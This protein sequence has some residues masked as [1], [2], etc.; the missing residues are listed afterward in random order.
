MDRTVVFVA[1]TPLTRRQRRD[2]EK[3]AVPYG[4]FSSRKAVSLLNM[5]LMAVHGN[6]EWVSGYHNGQ[7]YLN[8]KLIKER[9]KDL[10]EMRREA[11]SFLTRMAGVSQAWTVDD[12]IDRR[13]TDNPDATRRNTA[14]A[15]A[16]D[17]F[18]AIAPGWQEIDDDS[19]VEAPQTRPSTPACWPRQWPAFCAYA[20]P[21]EHHCLVCAHDAGGCGLILPL[22]PSTYVKLLFISL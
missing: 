18:L 17:I 16:G 2:D 6:G 19:D 21:T 15:S 14:M 3:W 13:A 8:H 11:A 22:Q 4:E 5:Y 20:L 1:G 7:V 9:G 10:E 12:V